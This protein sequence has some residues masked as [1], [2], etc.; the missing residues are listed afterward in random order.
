MNEEEE[1][2][3]FEILKNLKNILTQ[4][5]RKKYQK[6]ESFRQDLN[7]LN[8]EEILKALKNKKENLRKFSK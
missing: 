7:M 3:F 4:K 2:I 1:K 8:E 6:K 5:K